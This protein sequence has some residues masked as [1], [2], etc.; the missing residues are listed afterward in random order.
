MQWLSQYN[1][2]IFIRWI[3]FKFK[4]VLKLLTF[5]SLL[6]GSSA[7]TDL[8]ELNFIETMMHSN[9]WKINVEM[10]NAGADFLILVSYL[11]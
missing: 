6:N 2:N 5:H 3:G 11:I 8:V 4:T 9:K 7:H 1:Y 10:R